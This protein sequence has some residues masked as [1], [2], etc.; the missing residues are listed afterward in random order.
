MHQGNIYISDTFNNRIRK[1][2]TDGT[3]TTIAGNGTAGYVDGAG[4][5]TQN[6]MLRKA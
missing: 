1:I 4:S 2:A 5:E 6:S 3:V